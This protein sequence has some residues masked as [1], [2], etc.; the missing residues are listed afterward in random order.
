MNRLADL[1]ALA[2]LTGAAFDAAQGRMAVL[3]R[4]ESELR[5]R[6]AA[7]D[8][9]S[10]GYRSGGVA[11]PACRAEADLLW[12]RWADGRRRALTA[13]LAR[14]LSEIADAEEELRPAFGRREAARQ[15]CKDGREA[16]RRRDHMS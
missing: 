9:A 10:S 3:R 13:E 6:L 14:L 15:L 12:Q 7:I 16:L 1:E 2:A 4:R 11:D 5:Q 8:P